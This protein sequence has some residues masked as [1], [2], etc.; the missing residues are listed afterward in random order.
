MGDLVVVAPVLPTRETAL[1]R[2]LQGLEASPLAQLRW[3][4]HFAR[5]V[6]LPLDGPRLF[7]SSRFDAGVGSYIAALAGLPEIAEIWSH[8]EADED[9]HDP[10]SLRR[11]LTGNRVKSP[12][13]LP[14][15]SK[16]SVREV[17]EALELQSRL[18][19]LA[20]EAPRLGAAG[21]A[22]AFRERFAR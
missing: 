22:H 7:F 17:N 20:A 3:D 2:H 12:Y 11:Y 18:A 8:C 15:W 6:I 1:R 16:V 14:A 9:L 4:T 10:E 19:G 5:F 13:I 21:L